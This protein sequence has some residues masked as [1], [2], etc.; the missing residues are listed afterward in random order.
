MKP[1]P[2]MFGC[3][4]LDGEPLT[5]HHVRT[6]W[7]HCALDTTNNQPHTACAAKIISDVRSF[8]AVM[9]VES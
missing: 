7:S 8:V 2:I 6:S 5:S 4:M 3:W 1:E 9:V